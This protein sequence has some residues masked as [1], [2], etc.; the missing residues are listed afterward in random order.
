MK[1]A[2]FGNIRGDGCN[3]YQNCKYGIWCHEW[4]V[5]QFIHQK[6]NTSKKNLDRLDHFTKSEMQ[7]LTEFMSVGGV[8]CS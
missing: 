2:Q 1:I 4:F 5:I 6:H 8:I 3:D 7:V